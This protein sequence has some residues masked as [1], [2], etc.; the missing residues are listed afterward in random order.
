MRRIILT[1]SRL[2]RVVSQLIESVIAEASE[3]EKDA[4]KAQ[5]KNAADALREVP[6]YKQ[7]LVWIAKNV[8]V[9]EPLDDVLPLLR[10]WA[11]MRDEKRL[12]RG[13][14]DLT[15][16]DRTS[17][18]RI[19][20]RANIGRDIAH[21]MPE[22]IAS[23]G[24]WDI[25]LPMNIG[26]SCAVAQMASEGNDSYE[27][28]WCTA[29]NKNN[30]FF[31]YAANNILLYYVVNRA[32]P[33]IKYSL[34][35][36]NGIFIPPDSGGATV[37]WRNFAFDP[38]Q[39]FG[40]AWDDIMSEIESHTR[41][42]SAGGQHPAAARVIESASDPTAWRELVKRTSNDPEHLLGLYRVLVLPSEETIKLLKGRMR[43]GMVPM[44]PQVALK[45]LLVA[46]QAGEDNYDVLVTFKD[47]IANV[48]NNYWDDLNSTL[49]GR[50]IDLEIEKIARKSYGAPGAGHTAA[51]YISMLIDERKNLL[52]LGGSF[53]D[54]KD[55]KLLD[56]W[57]IDNASG[58][59]N[60]SARMEKFDAVESAVD[61]MPEILLSALVD[62]LRIFDDLRERLRDSKQ[63]RLAFQWPN[64]LWAGILLKRIMSWNEPVEDQSE[65]LIR[66]FEPYEDYLPL[67]KYLHEAARAML[68][69]EELERW[70]D[71]KDLTMENWNG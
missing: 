63:P 70:K 3:E 9:S 68:T 6:A 39:A 60:S 10:D 65:K 8:P 58:L 64:Q 50:N 32:K 71:L 17:L 43:N 51:S 67:M 18:E 54:L 22:R 1:E 33:E 35:F 28:T 16:L 13:E 34:G 2:R 38:E 52:R 29:R 55:W 44:H 37:D 59:P 12:L 5:L 7:M 56:D 27:I 46:S 45:F 69:S 61:E 11:R 15:K 25:Y 19:N 36:S 42:V 49:T 48:L 47:A 62:P 66:L 20:K 21:K 23:V 57:I 24:E 26:E 4:R 30:M 40:S 14:E 53:D 41:K 31:G